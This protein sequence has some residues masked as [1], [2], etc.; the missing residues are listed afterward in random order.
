MTAPTT[1][2]CDWSSRSTSDE[3]GFVAGPGRLAHGLPQDVHP[4][5]VRAQQEV[6]GHA[7]LG[8]LCGALAEQAVARGA[9]VRLRD[10]SQEQPY[11]VACGR[12]DL[13][14]LYVARQLGVPGKLLEGVPGHAPREFVDPG[15][16][17]QRECPG[18]G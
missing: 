13:Q 4:E 5:G 17:A 2:W 8:A 16:A 1:P 7:F 3:G 18:G 11:A 9:G 6:Q 12:G 14:V 10:A 15:L